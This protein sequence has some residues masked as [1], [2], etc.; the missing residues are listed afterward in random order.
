MAN[1]PLATLAAQISATGISAPPI[2]DILESEIATYEGIYGSDTVLTA[3]TQDGELISIRSTAINDCN[4]MAI[5]VYN[6]YSPTFAQGV[7]LSA[8]VQTNGLTRNTPTNSTAVVSIAGVVGTIIQ[9]GVAIDTN[10]NLWDLPAEVTIPESG[11]ITVTVTAQQPGAIAAIPGAINQPY[12][13]IVGWQTITNA[14]AATPGNPVETDAK[15]RG[16]QAVST[17]LPA[18]TPLQSIAAAIAQLTGVGRIYPYENQTAVTDSNGVPSHSIAMIVEGGDVTTIAQTIEATKSPGTG[19]YGTTQIQV[20]DPA[21]VPIRISFFELTE[22]PIFVAVTIQPLTGYVSTTATAIIN[23]IVAFLNA[24]PVG[25]EVYLN[26]LLAV[27]GLQNSALGQTFAITALTIGISSGSMGSTNIPISFNEA[28][29][30]V[31]ANV[32]V[33]T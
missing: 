31:T 15:L 28:A 8:A 21:G 2:E 23:A 30:G 16:R 29:Q 27:A 20:E 25:Q 12:T 6:S 1:Y 5:A 33:T 22:V 14:A 18:L 7:G 17:A 19:T 13:I 4:Q 24:L 9:D 32:T 3:D 11:A 26:W 10:G